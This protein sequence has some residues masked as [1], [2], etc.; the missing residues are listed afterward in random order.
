[1]KRLCLAILAFYA[2][3]PALARA[4]DYSSR[5]TETLI[6]ELT[7]LDQSAPGIDSSGDYEA[8]LAD[9]AQPKFEGGLLPPRGTTIPPAMRELVRRGLDALPALIAHLY[10]KRPTKLTIGSQ[11]QTGYFGGQYFADEYDPRVGKPC[12]SECGAGEENSW[13]LEMNCEM[14]ATNCPTFSGKYTVKVGDV[15]AVL[16]G[17]IVNRQLAAVRYQPTAILIVN[18]PIEQPSIGERIVRDWHGLDSSALEASLLADLRDHGSRFFEGALR[19][20][21][22]Y[23]PK[24]YAALSGKDLEK[25]NAFEADEKARK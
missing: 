17:Q 24:T 7:T 16:I 2:L 5:S 19:R 9:D 8:F 14:T 3:L 20:L 15:C 10:D 22:F 13:F 1:L 12:G 23:Y 21:R 4:D 18:S 6:G 11:D 25:R